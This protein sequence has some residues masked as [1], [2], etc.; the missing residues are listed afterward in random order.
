MTESFVTQ[1]PHCQTSFRVSY[2]Q[3]SA[4][5]GAVRCGSCLQVFNAARQL[6]EKSTGQSAAA[7]FGEAPAHSP[8]PTLGEAPAPAPQT[9]AQPPVLPH[10]PEAPA[11]RRVEPISQRR[12]AA[13]AEIDLEHLDLDNELARL[14]QRFTPTTGNAEH[15][16]PGRED[17]LSARRD[18][19]E[20]VDHDF[21]DD[22]S[23]TEPRLGE[24]QG[25][26]QGRQEL[27]AQGPLPP[28]RLRAERDAE[29][30]VYHYLA[31]DAHTPAPL[32]DEHLAPVTQPDARAEPSLTP[33]EDE[34]DE[35][36]R[37]A[38]HHERRQRRSAIEAADE[39][40][41]RVDATPLKPA[42][43]RRAEP[44][45]RD[46][47]LPDLSED[48]LELQ[49]QKSQSSWGKR[50]LWSLLAL[51]AALTLAGQYVAYHFDEL[52]RQDAYR[53]WFQQFCPVVG[54]EVPSK[55]DIAL[56]KSSNLVVRSH[57]QF[58]G[59][60]IVDAIIYNRAPFSQPF[61][62]LELRFADLDGKLIASRRFKP[63]E[64]LSG[65]LAGQT[66]MPPQ[67]PIHIALDILDPGSKAVNYSLS[68]QSPE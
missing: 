30:A 45:M 4:A 28:E 12:W 47:D 26:S 38:P 55:V 54:C 56:I 8:L 51:I 20:A 16:G 63:S 27:R 58:S 64:Y 2:H 25:I 62:L 66:D 50:L 10:A 15:P 60:L 33:L 40:L 46:A 21:D 13:A 24:H 23:L 11:Y 41:R 57:P 48:P 5:R 59:A 35:H 29:P 9:A 37:R 19:P 31:E 32:V 36:D 53:P 1:C 52:A 42:K 3:L 43:A 18:E 44:R 22:D 6:L 68:F 17:Q 65:D 14:E 7:L 34:F 61:P 39:S 67:T 49:W